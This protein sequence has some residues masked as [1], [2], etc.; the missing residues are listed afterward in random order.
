MGTREDDPRDDEGLD[1]G[2]GEE[3]AAALPP[4]PSKPTEIGMPVDGRQPARLRDPDAP[5]VQAPPAIDPPAAPVQPAWAPP[6]GPHEVLAR[7]IRLERVVAGIV[8][9][10][11]VALM[12]Y[13]CTVSSDRDDLRDEV[14]DLGRG[15][16]QVEE[17][18]TAE[19]GEK[20]RALA[21]VATCK[22]DRDADK[23]DAGARIAKVEADLSGCRT[24]VGKME[25]QQQ[26]AQ[27]KLAELNAMTERFQKMIDAG[28]LEVEIR[29]GQMVVKLPAA[30]LFASGSADLSRA[31]RDAIGKVA[32]VL[33]KMPDRRFTV[34]GH[35]DS[36]PT[37][38]TQFKSNWQLSSARAVTVTEALI[39]AGMKAENLVAAGYGEHA[40][41]AT[42][43]T[44]RG[45]LLNRRI[46]LI[47]EPDLA[48]APIKS[49]GK[50]K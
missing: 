41:I 23:T 34:A 38:G 3:P 19:Q 2:W 27:R 5:P 4:P 48:T 12:A 40:P 6:P 17:S 45:R 50:G 44:E 1:E 32:A 39:A 35:T 10:M 18:L 31:G 36:Y 29:R 28:T 25:S 16:Q 15:K 43:K 49:R 20:S 42:N 24:A 47:L 8:G 30:V 33:A 14:A 11:F 7:R 37:T 13:S 21:A 46:E 26:E 22:K 9:A